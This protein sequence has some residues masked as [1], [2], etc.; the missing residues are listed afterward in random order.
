MFNIRIFVILYFIQLRRDMDRQVVFHHG[1]QLQSRSLET[2]RDEILVSL[3]LK[4]CQNLFEQQ[5]QAFDADI[6]VLTARRDGAR[7]SHASVYRNG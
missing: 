7:S 4:E 1:F 6:A 5:W 3:L 2:R